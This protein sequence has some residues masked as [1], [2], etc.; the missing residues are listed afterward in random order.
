MDALFLLSGKVQAV[1]GEWLQMKTE[2]THSILR[3]EL[4][5]IVIAKK[6]I[7][8][9]GILLAIYVLELKLRA[10]LHLFLYFTFA[11]NVYTR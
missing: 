10:R 6:A 1:R 9:R 4:E 11:N 5:K 3:E 7:S 8:S 2:Y